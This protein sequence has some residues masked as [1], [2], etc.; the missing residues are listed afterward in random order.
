M[1]LKD[2]QRRLTCLVAV[3]LLALPAAASADDAGVDASADAGAPAPVVKNKKS[4]TIDFG[5]TDGPAV[6]EPIKTRK[7]GAVK[8]GSLMPD[9]YKRPGTP[10]TSE[11]KKRGRGCAGCNDATNHTAATA[12]FLVLLL[13]VRRRH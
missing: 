4:T 13:V 12:L 1:C 10:T 8:H 9:K 2:V 11:R 6:A 5:E 7:P 3:A